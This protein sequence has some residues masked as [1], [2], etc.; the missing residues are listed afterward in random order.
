MKCYLIGIYSPLLIYA[1]LKTFFKWLV[2]I[3]KSKLCAFF[4]DTL[5]T[6]TSVFKFKCSIYSQIC[7][8]VKAWMDNPNFT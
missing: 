2:F 6:L 5:D 3:K 4:I 7:L 1:K 8:S